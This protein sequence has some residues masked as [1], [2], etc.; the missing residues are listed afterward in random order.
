MALS[1]SFLSLDSC[2]YELALSFPPPTLH[3]LS[4][5]EFLLLLNMGDTDTL[6]AQLPRG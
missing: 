4:K 6:I 1:L 2:P 3:P 5:L